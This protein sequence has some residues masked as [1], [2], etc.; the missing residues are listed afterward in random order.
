M[1]DTVVATLRY[2]RDDSEALQREKAYILNYTPPAGLP[3]SNFS[4][5]FFPGIEIHNLR[6]AATNWDES[7]VKIAKLGSAGGS[8]GGYRM[9]KDDFEDEERIEKEYLPVCIFDYMVR[10]REAA[11]PYQPKAKDNSPQPALSAHIGKSDYTT[12]E[13]Q[14]R[15]KKYFKEKAAEYG[16]RHY[17]I[18]K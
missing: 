2:A 9:H 10:R 6:T 17:Q 18:V 11:F 3:K 16:A 4:I 7:G 5:D 8:T 12:D 15:V 1:G 14:G 13:I